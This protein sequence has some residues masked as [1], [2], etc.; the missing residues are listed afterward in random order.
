MRIKRFEAKDS[1]T[2]LA[3]I[4]AEMG[5]DAVILATKKL[6]KDNRSGKNGCQSRIEIVAAIDYDL[7]EI[8]LPPP[9]SD[10]TM[11]DRSSSRFETYNRNTL[12][13]RTPAAETKPTFKSSSQQ[14]GTSV[15]RN[16]SRQQIHSEAR[17]LRVSFANLV[18]PPTDKAEKHGEQKNTPDKLKP[19]GKADPAEVAVWRDQLINN[20]LIQE[21]LPLISFGKQQI[22]ALVGA[23]G[24]GKTTTAAKLAAFYSL[25]QGKKVCLLSMDCYR[26]GA[27]DQ[28]RTYARIMRLPC[29]IVLRQ[30]ELKKAIDRHADKDVI[31][32]DTAGK[33]PYDESHVKELREWFAAVPGI[34][35]HLVLSATTKKEDIM[36]SL[37]AY[38]PLAISSLVLSKLDE[39]RAYASLCQ[40]VVSSKLPISYLSTGQR[41]PEDFFVAS[42]DFLDRL[43]KKGWDAAAAHFTRQAPSY[44]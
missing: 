19:R 13:G 25:H 34:R 37:K 6:P 41:V 10:D 17:D 27:T 26:I 12:R 15:Q 39:T 18:R 9:G 16:G 14:T 22:I 44:S 40:Q 1:T 29:E 31:I 2:A 30:N 42:K 23:T 21:P 11:I 4:K 36:R 38:T 20:L 43:F 35:P 7:D 3:M 8:S 28:L 33:S 32:I 5:E 24:V